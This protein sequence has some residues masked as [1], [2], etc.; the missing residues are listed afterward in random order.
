MRRAFDVTLIDDNDLTKLLGQEKGHKNHE[1]LIAEAFQRQKI[2]R[3]RLPFNTA[4]MFLRQVT[5]GCI[6]KIKDAKEGRIARL[7][8]I[9]LRRVRRDLDISNAVKTT[10]RAK[11][12]EHALLS[13]K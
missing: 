13:E 12:M 6:G 10:R 7:F 11:S 5:C 1:E 3:Q 4:R 8:G 9:G 2:A